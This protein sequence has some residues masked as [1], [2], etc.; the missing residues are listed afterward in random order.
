MKNRLLNHIPVLLILILT[1][2]FANLQINKR[3]D[4]PTDKCFNICGDARG[5]YAWLPAIF[6][7][8]DLNFH[9]FETVEMTSSPCG[10]Q[11]G[12]PIQDY[13]YTFNGKAIDKYYPGVSCMM[14][15]MFLVAHMATKWFTAYPADGYSPLYFKIM[16]L[17]SIVWFCMG[18]L[19]FLSVLSKLQ[20][21]TL[22]KTLTI[23]FIIF[24][25][26]A[27]YYTVDAPLYSHIYSFALIAAFLHSAL[28]LKESITAR[29][30]VWLSFL[31]GFI[32]MARPVNLSI[33]L[34]LPFLLQRQIPAFT[35]YFSE[36]KT[37]T[38]QLLPV[39]IMP[40]VLFTLYKIS[41]GRFFLY[42]YGK[43]GF[44]FL[45]PHILQF[46][47]SYDNSILLYTPLLLVPVLFAVTMYKNDH[48]HL[49]IGVIVTIVATIYIHSS[50]WAWSYGFSFGARTMLDFLPVSGILIGLSLKEAKLK[51][52]FTLPVYILCC[53]LTMLLYQQ[54]SANGYM[55]KYP[56]T[57]YWAAIHH[58]LGIKS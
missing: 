3:S 24:G 21:N 23:L 50:W 1:L 52:Y 16:G 11:C 34:I 43:E 48:K 5:Y 20:L 7:Y 12:I 40:V 15:P 8:R 35:A 25:S 22:Q 58:G 10:A 39:F 32:F 31:T 2:L 53:C 38:V 55:N 14:L 29:Q 26:N 13:R 30:I 18:M 44:D 41:I 6:I 56:I 4:S 37:R 42:S 46:L 51:K 28:C 36:Q 33:V 19:I 49:I 27:M 54:K 45:H 57:D 47:F 9:F 17:S